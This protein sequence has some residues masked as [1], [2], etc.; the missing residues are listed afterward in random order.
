MLKYVKGTGGAEALADDMMADYFLDLHGVL[1]PSETTEA[2]EEREETEQ[3]TT[4]GARKRVS[5]NPS[6]NGF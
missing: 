1:P 3:T 6:L 5:F 2:I 4:L